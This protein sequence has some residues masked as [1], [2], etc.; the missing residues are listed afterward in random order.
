VREEIRRIEKETNLP[1]TDIA[2]K[3]ISNRDV[4]MKSFG[5][6]VYV[7]DKNTGEI[8]QKISAPMAPSS[9]ERRASYSLEIDRVGNKIL[10]EL[11]KGAPDYFEGGK[12]KDARTFIGF[13]NAVAKESG[14]SY[15]DVLARFDPIIY[16][17]DKKENEFNKMRQ[18]F[19]KA[20][21]ISSSSDPLLLFS[22]V[23]NLLQ[24]QQTNQ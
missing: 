13:I 1:I 16:M 17:S 23:A 18:E 11:A 24:E 20:S 6:T 10:Q 12:L 9:L 4:E 14:A 19:E 21:K 8:L 5:G 3:L 22:S 2:Q 7:Y 15:N